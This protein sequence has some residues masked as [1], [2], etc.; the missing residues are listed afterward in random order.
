MIKR[1]NK[2]PDFFLDAL[3]EQCIP[4][5]CHYNDHSILTKNGELIQ[6]IKIEGYLEEILSKDKNFDLRAVIRKA[7]TD[8]ITNPKIAVWFHTIRRKTNL[9]SI[10]NYSW[11]FAKDTHE[12]WSQKNYWRSKFVNELYITLIHEAD[13]H[14]L[15]DNLALSF[16]PKKLKEKHLNKLAEHAISLDKTISD[17]LAVLKK[18]GGKRLKVEHDRFGAHS[19]ILEFLA[20]I[21]CLKNKRIGLPIQNIDNIFKKTK[22]A[23]GGNSLEVLDNK[24]KH[25]AAIFSIKEHQDLNS[26]AL[27]N[28]LRISSEYIISQTLNF[29][30]AKEAKKD[31]EQFD[32]ILTEI[33]EDENLK[34]KSG[35]TATLN[36]DKG[37]PTDYGTQQVTLSIIGESLEEL[38]RSISTATKEIRKLGIVAVR[39]DL[40]MALCFWSQLPGNFHFFRRPSYINTSRT[41]S[42]AS[43]HNTPSGQTENIWG[44]AITLFRKENGAP[45]FFNLHEENNGNTM[46]IGPIDSSKN[47]LV[48]FLLSESSK[49]NPNILYID[50]FYNSKV[51]LKALGGRYEDINLKQQ[52]FSF[53]PLK[54]KDTPENRDFLKNWLMLLI[55]ADKAA[56]EKQKDEIYKAVDSLLEDKSSKLK[57]LSNLLDL[58]KDKESKSNL[59]LWCKPNELGSLFDNQIDEL[60]SGSQILGLNIA[61]L[62]KEQ[63]PSL[64]PALVSYCL[65]QYAQLLDKSPTIIAVNDANL[66]LQNSIFTNMLPNWLDYL[67][68]N[69][70]LAIFICNSTKTKIHSNISLIQE[71][72]STSIFLPSLD[73]QA[74]QEALKLSDEEILRIKNMKILYRH[75]MIKQKRYQ[76]IAEL[77]LDGM[78]YAI[79]ALTGNKDALEAMDKAI[80][81]VGENPNRWIIPFY[82]NLFPEF[83]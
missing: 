50:Q 67:S 9:D 51:T 17:V 16:I 65:Y 59:S 63:N 70:G 49:Y 6:V 73:P 40:H 24:E 43:L 26:K 78:E 42:F 68:A 23:F 12:S 38:A 22:A 57:Q 7:I 10:N 55:F 60:G 8:N 32:N 44:K 81:E 19:Q 76:I 71:K 72:L 83:E 27:D 48:N 37:N 4:Y 33:S 77:N 79:K 52:N 64:V 25:F 45:H 3:K 47:M 15:K 54:I 69:N 56:T 39:E 61:E 75:F 28:L 13:D 11:T 1:S 18:Y 30:D 29:V 2:N 36:S 41:A 53:N 74:Y 14:N 35:L 62:M 82:K 34:T 20:K 58:I 21:I 66:L 5:A 31:L 80:L 46:V